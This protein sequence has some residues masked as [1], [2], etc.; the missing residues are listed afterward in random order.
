MSRN[1]ARRV[2]KFLRYPPMAS[3]KVMA[4]RGQQLAFN[5]WSCPG[6]S[7]LQGVDRPQDK[8]PKY[9]RCRHRCFHCIDHR[10]LPCPY[11]TPPRWTANP[12]NYG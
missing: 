2:S 7:A 3:G 11:L 9:E 1:R 12:C 10:A 5:P 6:G 4:G 8:A